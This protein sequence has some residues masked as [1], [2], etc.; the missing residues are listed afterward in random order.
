MRTLASNSCETNKHLHFVNRPNERIHQNAICLYV[1]MEYLQYDMHKHSIFMYCTIQ[2]TAFNFC[3]NKNIKTNII[4]FHRC[5]CVKFTFCRISGSVFFIFVEEI[6]CKRRKAQKIVYMHVSVCVFLF[7][8]SYKRINSM[9]Q[10]TKNDKNY[11]ILMH[12]R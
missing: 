2:T 5:V 1:Q 7:R 11:I 8:F 4:I 9:F 10:H 3:K 12:K 6:E